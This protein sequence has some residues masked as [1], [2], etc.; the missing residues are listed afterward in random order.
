MADKSSLRIL[1]PPGRRILQ[2]TLLTNPQSV[3]IL[4]SHCPLSSSN[5]L[6]IALAVPA[7]GHL[8]EQF[9]FLVVTQTTLV[10]A[11]TEVYLAVVWQ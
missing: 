8:V 7:R 6:K 10:A 4:N 3:R 2:I 9:I 5:P 1:L 11:I